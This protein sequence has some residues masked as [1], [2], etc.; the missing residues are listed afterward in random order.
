MINCGAINERARCLFGYTSDIA[1]I[2]FTEF[3]LAETA[4]KV[5]IYLV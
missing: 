3:H 5:M 2:Q 1:E 4:L